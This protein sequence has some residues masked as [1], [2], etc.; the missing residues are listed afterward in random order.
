MN[1]WINVPKA[2]IDWRVWLPCGLD[3]NERDSFMVHV[4]NSSCVPGTV[5]GTYKISLNKTKIDQEIFL[6]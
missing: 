3:K 4:L 5:L 2:L 6:H 1:E